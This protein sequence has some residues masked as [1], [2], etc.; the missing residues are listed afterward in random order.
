MSSSP[1]GAAPGYV[2]AA[3]GFDEELVRLRLLQERYD[4]R[5]FDRLTAIGP[6]AGA[7]CLE[8]G[9]GAGSV[10][11]WLAAQ[12]GPSGHV[13]ATDADPRFLAGIEAAGI[14][15]RRHDIL[16]DPLEPARY[17]LVHC[18]A[19]LCH[20]PDPGRALGV[21]AAA[22]RPGGWLL[23][24]DADYC[25]L[26]AA[27]PAHPLSP[28][29]DA[30]MR[31]ILA[32]IA[33]GRAFNPFFG[34]CLPRL[35][36]SAGLADAGHEAIACHRQGAGSAAEM[37][38]RSLERTCNRTLRDGAVSPGEF[39]AVLSALWDPSFSFVDALS[40]AAWGQPSSAVNPP[41]PIHPATGQAVY[42]LPE[43]DLASPR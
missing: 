21:M 15:V 43:P 36:E 31:K 14:E 9:A 23:A 26:V 12:A 41:Q 38:A 5:T 39:A 16:A 27:D 42:A 13:V 24:E 32:F 6:L 2:H 28:R 11:R 17:D 30:I 35:A 3:S 29:F 7:V 18:R 20:L 1:A 25:S 22:V 37:L 10:A 8:V 19:L 40:V 34:R 4:A 33:A